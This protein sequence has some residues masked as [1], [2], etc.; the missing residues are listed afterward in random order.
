[1][2]RELGFRASGLLVGV[3]LLAV[4][5][6]SSE[7]AGPPAPVDVQTGG[8]GSSWVGGG[9]QP[10]TA[11]SVR[12]CS[13]TLGEHNGVLNCYHGQQVCLDGQWGAC[14]SGEVSSLPAPGE[15]LRGAPGF[16][17]MAKSAEACEDNPCEPSCL[18]L[19][20]EPEQG[21]NQSV[22][23]GSL[24]DYEWQTGTLSSFPSGLVTKGLN[25]PCS[26]GYDCQ[27]NTRC[28]YPLSGTC[29]HSKCTTG[30]YLEAACDPCVEDICAVDPSCC[31]GVTAVEDSVC[32]HDPCLEGAALAATCDPC[33]TAICQDYPTCCT[34]VWD[35]TCTA[36]VVSVCGN[37][38]GCRA[39]ELAYDGACYYKEEADESW[40][41]ARTNCRARGAGWDLAAVNDSAENAF[42]VA[43][44]IDASETWIG[45][46]D[47]NGIGSDGRWRW[48]SGDPAGEWQ[49]SAAPGSDVTVVGYG[50]IWK[51]NA[52]NV[53]PGGSWNQVGFSDAGWPSGPAEL[54]FGDNDEATSFSRNGPSYYFRH[55]FVLTKLPTEATLDVV[56]DDGFVAY[57]N[58]TEVMRENV[59]STAHT[60]TATSL[61]SDNE[62]SSAAIS[63]SP[64]VIGTNVVAVVV[65]NRTENNVDLSFDLNLD[66]V[67][68]P[69]R[70]IRF[71]DDWSYYSEAADPGADWAGPDFDDSGWPAGG[72]QLGFGEG[73]ETTSF[74][75]TGASYYFRKH[76]T[77]TETV[78][79]ATLSVLY[80]DGFVAYVNGVEVLREN[81]TDTSHGVY[82]S[83]N[84]VDDA[85]DTAPISTSPFIVGDNVVAIMVKNGSSGSNDVSFDAELELQLSGSSAYA[86]FGWGEPGGNEC[87]IFQANR[88][89]TWADKGCNQKTDSVCEGPPK[90]MAGGGGAPLSGSWTAIDYGTTWKYLATGANP[91]SSWM[92]AGFV[93]SGWASGI[94]QLGYGDGDEATS[95]GAANPSYYFRRSI[96]VPTEISDATLSVVYDDG[97]VA[98]VNGTEV[99]R[100]NVASTSHSSYASSSSGDNAVL[101]V[102]ISKDAFVQGQNTIAV[103]VKNSSS[104]SS[105]ISFDLKLQVTLC[106]ASGCPAEPTWSQSCIEKVASVCDATCDTREPPAS[107]GQCVSW[108]P[109]EV[110]PSC[111]GVDL[112]LGVPCDSNIPVCN[113]GTV[114]APAGV[115]LVHFPANSGHYP[116]CTPNLGHPQMEECFTTS[117][118]PPGEC[119]NVTHCP[120]LGGNREIMVNP[121]GAAHVD[122]CSCRDNWSLYSA[123]ECG[124]PS[125]G[126]GSS[127]ATLKKKP[128]DIIFVI[129]NS[130][131]MQGEIAQVQQRINEDFAQIIEDSGVD[132][133]VIMV[134]RYG[135]LSTSVGNSDYPICVSSPLG[136]HNCSNPIHQGVA[137]NP[138]H[139]YHFSTDVGSRD[140][141]CRLLQ[142]YSNADELASDYRAWTPVAPTGY[143]ELLRADARKAFVVITDDR[144][145]C[146]YGGYS[147]NDYNTVS[148]GH[149]VAAA[150]DAALLALSPEQFGTAAERNYV[151]HSIVAMSEYSPA[152]S[153]WPASEPVQ[154]GECWPGAQAPGTGYQGLSV[155]TGGL[156]YPTCRNSDF[157]AI[158]QAVAEEVVE[159][160]TVSCSVDLEDQGSADPDDTTV[161]FVPGGSVNPITF[162]RVA[163]S[164]ACV[165]NSYYYEDADTITLCPT[166]CSM[167]QADLSGSLAVEVGCNGGE[168]YLARTITQTYE[169]E[170]N[171]D[172]QVQWGFLT[173]NTTTPGDS[174]VT[175]RI[176]TA[177]TEAALATATWTDLITAQASPDTQVC[178]WAGP[179]PCPIDLYTALGGSPSA[180][181]P[182]VEM[183]L[184][185]NPSSDGRQPSTLQAW[186][187][188]YSCP[189]SQ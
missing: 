35:E 168:S 53:D 160:A 146:S 107:T 28:Q 48:S 99:A 147:F 97:F 79:D 41:D 120:G 26:S 153:P 29:S 94:G 155:L 117:P 108:Y 64:F 32:A 71:N 84:S 123:G 10:C 82:A 43:D 17:L 67:Y 169:S 30:G 58:G 109:G 106:G 59:S 85:V 103:M 14:G 157:N 175:F 12:D 163:G 174:N 145:S 129:D 101:S 40:A 122:E 179:A 86:N 93:D 33:V 144:V 69:Q 96:N 39:G 134:S 105:D 31:G 23:D 1:M 151:F 136:G 51:Y 11:G 125:C 90:Q 87:A 22:I 19:S 47:G 81:V 111:G 50:S 132:Y 135:D 46:T 72:A 121:E 89:G 16:R 187:L 116:S 130:G 38:C 104:W 91:G 119:I 25:E 184:S 164:G 2:H 159:G 95:F 150:F 180:H 80:D 57:I 68:G 185:L 98:Y 139:F 141:L 156:R 176:R 49:E 113:H 177:E 18:S 15:P 44:V 65:K 167:V 154:T 114:E 115:R 56:F 42:L 62:I 149:N 118:I 138:P 63:V 7:R 9:A 127:V 100:R 21:S 158:F 45:F 142:G 182:F 20:E 37:T 88:V 188:T 66:V 172:T 92:D 137:H 74:A 34:G 173:Y 55:S 165:D 52:T 8:G 152:T 70:V 83:A 27:F 73:D 3:A 54:G 181:H 189:F 171:E 140:G 110:D 76:L 61:S 148:G 77:L 131:S 75:K 128:V 6:C 60:S 124:E 162:S 143:R 112:A 13:I 5:A 78:D 166:T 4:S 102:P 178:A 170:C 133:R 183:E 24:S 36:A 126:G 186:E 161:R